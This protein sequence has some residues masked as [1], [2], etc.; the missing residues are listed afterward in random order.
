MDDD[1]RQPVEGG[2]PGNRYTVQ[3]VPAP[4]DLRAFPEAK[5]ARP[6]TTV[7]GRGLRRRWKDAKG[8]IYEWDYRHGTVEVY[9][10]HG[11]H[12]GEFDPDTG[13]QLR[14]ADPARRVDP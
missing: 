10:S 6:K 2:D 13:K 14:D 8:R 12:L 5:R 4:K 3:I 11:N 1:D 9:D 7:R